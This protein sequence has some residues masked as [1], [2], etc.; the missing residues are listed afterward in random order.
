MKAVFKPCSS[1]TMPAGCYS[2][3][4]QWYIYPDY[5]LNQVITQPNSTPPFPAPSTNASLGTDAAGEQAA[6]DSFSETILGKGVNLSC[7]YEGTSYTGIR[8]EYIDTTSTF[9]LETCAATALASEGSSN[10]AASYGNQ[11]ISTA[12]WAA[13]LPQLH[14]ECQYAA[15]V[16]ELYASYNQIVEN[17]FISN[18][19]QLLNLASDAKVPT[20]TTISTVPQQLIEGITYT[21]LSA[22]GDV[23]AG[24]WAN[25][26]ETSANVATA[27]G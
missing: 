8:C 20:T 3:P 7:T 12:D 10:L 26:M 21:V 6:Y 14:S 18:S 11:L 24:I 22:T 13:V 23:G 2:P 16:Q 1:R 15:D 5:Y 27:G 25:L 19:N 17:V 9:T 4:S